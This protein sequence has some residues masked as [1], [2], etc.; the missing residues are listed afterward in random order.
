MGEEDDSTQLYGTKR[1]A[2]DE[3]GDVSSTQLYN[4]TTDNMDED[5]EDGNINNNN[6]LSQKP[7]K[8][9]RKKLNVCKAHL[10]F[11]F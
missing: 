8:V 10:F 3:D 7:Q 5:F 6:K 11:C 9:P 4:S 2:S 1:A